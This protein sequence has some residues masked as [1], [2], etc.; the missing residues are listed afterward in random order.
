MAIQPV[1]RKNDGYIIQ[2][3]FAGP[4]RQKSRPNT[5]ERCYGIFSPSKQKTEEQIQS[6]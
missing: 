6:I 5:I 2:Y 4:E 3:N 1:N